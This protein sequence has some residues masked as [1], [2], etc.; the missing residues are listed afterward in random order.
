MEES[1]ENLLSASQFRSM[2]VSPTM[3]PQLNETICSCHCG[4]GCGCTGPG[5]DGTNGQV[6]DGESD[7]AVESSAS[8]DDDEDSL[9][10]GEI[11]DDRL[12]GRVGDQ[13]NHSV[14][15]PQGLSNR[16]IVWL[17]SG[18]ED[19]G[20]DEPLT[21]WE[22][23]SAHPST[24]GKHEDLPE[25]LYNEPCSIEARS[26]KASDHRSVPRMSP[27]PGIGTWYVPDL[28]EGWVADVQLLYY[29]NVRPLRLSPEYQH[30]RGNPVAHLVAP[31]EITFVGVVQDW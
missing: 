9:L 4:C 23:V 22:Q 2:T 24:D 28:N 10:G 11:H 16:T 1:Y 3:S 18:A 17:V 14:L 8:S 20:H 29:F 30:A 5:T 12:D 15:S 31:D 27:G 7:T 26:N 19:T 6:N 13:S 21:N 25:S